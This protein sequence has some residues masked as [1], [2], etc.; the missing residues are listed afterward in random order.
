MSSFFSRISDTI[1]DAKTK[2]QLMSSRGVAGSMPG[3]LKVI[4]R[5][6]DLEEM[7]NNFKK[8]DEHFSR[9]HDLKYGAHYLL[10]LSGGN[11][12]TRDGLINVL[13]MQ[14]ALA[15]FAPVGHT[16]TWQEGESYLQLRDVNKPEEPLLKN[17]QN[18]QK[19]NLLNQLG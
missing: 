8:M 6:A 13:L 4:V 1:K 17:Q 9:Q 11:Y 14:L 19:W 16:P 18:I 12:D 10:T 5:L 7:F 3:D 2:R 15:G